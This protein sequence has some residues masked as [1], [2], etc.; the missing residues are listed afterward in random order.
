[1][2][3]I[4]PARLSAAE[5]GGYLVSFRDLPEAHTEGDNEAE[6]LTHASDC[7]EEVLAFYMLD[8]QPI[9]EPSTLRR[10]EHL[11]APG[12]L[13]AAKTALYI[14][15]NHSG[16]AQRELARRMKVD[17]SQVT[18]LL[19]PRHRSRMD[20]IDLAMRALGARLTLSLDKAA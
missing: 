9:P 14:A 16:L 3:L 15:L 18:R 13:M 17:V 19:D 10:G 11:V 2:R 4:Y 7:L 1:M 12:S 20:Q 8:R 5:E 6:A